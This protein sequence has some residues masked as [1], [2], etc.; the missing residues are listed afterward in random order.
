MSTL[1]EHIE[2]RL[3]FRINTGPVLFD[4]SMVSSD[5]H[6]IQEAVDEIQEQEDA[7]F[8]ATMPAMLK[9]MR[10][11]ELRKNNKRMKQKRARCK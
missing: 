11:D 4:V 5:E 7:L 8:I 3:E 6:A 10:R 2:D 9:K 1:R